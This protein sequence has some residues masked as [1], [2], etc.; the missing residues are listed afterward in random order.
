LAPQQLTEDDV[1]ALTAWMPTSERLAEV[2][3][4]R[5]SDVDLEG[6]WASGFVVVDDWGAR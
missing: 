4:L 1:E 2:C 6:Y 3:G 5:W